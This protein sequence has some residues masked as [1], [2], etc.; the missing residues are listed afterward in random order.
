[1]FDSKNDFF[2]KQSFETE[3]GRLNRL[4]SKRNVVARLLRI[5]KFTKVEVEEFLN[6]YDYFVDRPKS[7]DGATI[8]KDA[9]DIP[10][11]EL[12]AML[13]DY[14]YIVYLSFKT[15]LNWLKSKWRYDKIYSD[16]L[17]RLGRLAKWRSKLRF[18]LLTASTPFYPIWKSI[19]K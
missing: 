17:I 19:K 10:K 3:L 2:Q 9:Y 7:F 1:M 15:G 5:K 14:H 6:A 12:S 18:V 11:L 8:V 13:H 16:N 4:Q